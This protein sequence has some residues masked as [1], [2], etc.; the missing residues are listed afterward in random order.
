MKEDREILR[1]GGFAEHEMKQLSKL[2]KDYSEKEK[3]LAAADHRRL[4]FVRWL[5]NTGKLS[6]QIAS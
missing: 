2:R 1:K 5:V 6:E 3:Q 4:E